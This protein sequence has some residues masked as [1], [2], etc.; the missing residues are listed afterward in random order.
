MDSSLVP[1]GGAIPKEIM[2]IAIDC[3]IR[4]DQLWPSAFCVISSAIGDC[5]V[6]KLCYI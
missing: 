3:I 2:G 1:Y 4:M 6:W 5:P